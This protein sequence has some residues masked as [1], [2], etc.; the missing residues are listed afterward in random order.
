MSK[1][2]SFSDYDKYMALKMDFGLW[3]VIAYF[4]RPIILKVASIRMG[5]GGSGVTGAGGL[6]D[7]LYPD[8]FGF[9]IAL[10]VTIPAVLVLIAYAKRKPGASSFIRRIWSNGAILLMVTAGLNMAI[11]VLPLITGS[12]HHLGVY[13]WGQMAVAVCIFGYLLASSRVKDTFADFPVESG[14]ESSKGR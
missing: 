5:R 12:I 2:Y 8:D 14:K 11:V 13:G 9:F 10:A 7:I 3:L 1:I 6:K 4:L